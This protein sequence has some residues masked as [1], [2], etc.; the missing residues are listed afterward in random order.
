MALTGLQTCQHLDPRVDSL[1]SRTVRHRLLYFIN[2]PPVVFC[3]S[4]ST[5]RP[6]APMT[7]AAIVLFQGRAQL[8]GPP[9]GGLGRQSSGHPAAHLQHGPRHQQT[10]FCQATRKEQRLPPRGLRRL[11]TS[12]VCRASAGRVPFWYFGSGKESC[13]DGPLGGAHGPPS[14]LEVPLPG[15]TQRGAFLPSFVSQRLRSPC[16]CHGPP[17]H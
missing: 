4:S 15:S 17:G 12:G 11:L 13:A 14:L 10:P 9:V 1:T 6:T 16:M 7:E 3:H 8:S 5:H 2:H